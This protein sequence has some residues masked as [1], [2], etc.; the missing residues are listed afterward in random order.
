MPEMLKETRK[1]IIEKYFLKAE[2]LNVTLK[3]TATSGCALKRWFG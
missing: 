2:I 3:A 1:N